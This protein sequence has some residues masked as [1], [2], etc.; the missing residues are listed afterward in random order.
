MY[1]KEHKY[2]D[3]DIFKPFRDMAEVFWHYWIRHRSLKVDI[4]GRWNPILKK[5]EY[6]RI[7]NWVDEPSEKIHE[8]GYRQI[9]GLHD[10]LI[11]WGVPVYARLYNLRTIEII[12]PNASQDT[13]SFLYDRM[14]SN[15]AT[16][17]A[18][19]LAR[20]AAIAGMDIQKLVLM[21]GIA[22]AAIIGMKYMGMF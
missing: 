19:G 14:K 5:E 1:S 21:G 10:S 12:D 6:H 11:W 3:R 20:V 4:V 18:R 2:T 17:W 13:P 16:K 7:E 22:V 9:V 15:L 8:N